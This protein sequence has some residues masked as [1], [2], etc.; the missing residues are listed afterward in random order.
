MVTTLKLQTCTT[1]RWGSKAPLSSALQ[2]H[3]EGIMLVWE[4]DIWLL[5]Q[6]LLLTDCMTLGIG[7][8]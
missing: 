1:L 5:V 3:V 7:L 2:G 6:T 8:P 4:P